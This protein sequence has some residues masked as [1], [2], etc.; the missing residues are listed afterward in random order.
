MT[1]FDSYADEYVAALD[2]GLAIS[3]ENRVFFARGR[4]LW[5]AGCL[6]K[7][8]FTP[9]RVID[10]GCGTGTTVP[11]LRELLGA[12]F[13]IGLDIS[14]R[15]LE[16]ARVAHQS[17]PVE[18]KLT[19]EYVPDGSADLVYCNG[20]FHHIQPNERAEV[21]G[22]IARCLR[23]D[24]IFALW[25]NNPWNPGTRFVMSRIPFDKDA[26]TLSARLAKALVR[27][28]G[29]SVIKTDYC[30]IFPRILRVLRSVEPWLS[31]FP[32]GAQ[33]QV[34]CKNNP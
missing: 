20:V 3:G 14:P 33:Y 30:F 19:G 18:Y 16:I 31:G 9:K 17:L 6:K 5:L 24:G 26:V 12:D 28:A 15:S 21:L 23:P 22:Y 10:Y 7:L 34:L 2:R 32:I 8:G 25:E 11:Y 13:V 1:D 4:V 29:F 27:R